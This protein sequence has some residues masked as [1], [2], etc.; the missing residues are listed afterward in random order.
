MSTRNNEDTKRQVRKKKKIEKVYK[1]V[2][3]EEL[4]K[5]K[6]TAISMPSVYWPKQIQRELK[7]LVAYDNYDNSK[8]TPERVGAFQKYANMNVVENGML[9][10]EVY[11]EILGLVGATGVFYSK[12]IVQKAIKE[13]D[14]ITAKSLLSR[15]VFEKR[16]SMFVNAGWSV[17]EAAVEIGTTPEALLNEDNWKLGHGIFV[18]PITGE[19]HKFVFRENYTGSIWEEVDL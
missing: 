6:S 11:K 16:E 2:K 15:I 7:E 5:A 4:E 14:S 8:L 17:E 10:E 18:D 1:I 19:M 9:N 12:A 3:P 13:S